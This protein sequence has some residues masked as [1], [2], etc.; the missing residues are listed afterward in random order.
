MFDEI[1]ETINRVAFSN[2]SSNTLSSTDPNDQQYRIEALWQRAYSFLDLHFLETNME[3]VNVDIQNL[4]GLELLM[5][6]V[7]EV[8]DSKDPSKKWLTRALQDAIQLQE[9]H[10]ES[11]ELSELMLEILTLS[12]RT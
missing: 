10:Q 2:S 6:E 8:L 4:P 12:K 9:Y 7:Q 5:K 11:P 3:R 1:S